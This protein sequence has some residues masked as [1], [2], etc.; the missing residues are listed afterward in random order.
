MIVTFS[1]I[2]KK[3]TSMLFFPFV[4]CLLGVILVACGSTNTSSGS[5][6]STASATCTATPNATQAAAARARSNASGTIQSVQSGS[7]V[8]ATA[9]KGN[10]NVTISSTTRI[11]QVEAVA[12]SALKEGASASLQVK[13]D[14]AGNYTATVITVTNVTGQNGQTFP[15][16][17]NGNG[18]FGA[19]RGRAGCGAGRFGQGG[20]GTA[21]S[22]Q[23]GS[24]GNTNTRF[25][26]GTIGQVNGQQLTITDTQ[27]NDYSV[28]VD[29]STRITQTV[30][31][32]ANDLKTGLT[33]AVIGTSA[34]NS[35]I[36]AQSITI[37]APGTF[38]SNG[39][40]TST[41]S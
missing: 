26:F 19:G 8:V 4:F 36:T 12:L 41:N 40:P 16:G 21:T 10:V 35:A 33:V 3:T 32:T 6:Q 14:S 24:T 23:N 9:K 7:L 25:V 29:S 27:G 34:D 17:G 22:G 18:T 1:R 20:Q 15:R 30:S 13:Q 31:A 39:T 2:F 28:A 11:S 5:A 37:S 38:Q